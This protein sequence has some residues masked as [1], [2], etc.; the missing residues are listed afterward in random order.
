M[1]S[2][3]FYLSDRKYTNTPNIALRQLIQDTECEPLGAH[4]VSSN[5]CE[6]V[7]IPWFAP[8]V[9]SDQCEPF[10]PS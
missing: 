6:P 1:A 8:S 3:S 5:E 10:D 4:G 2:E 7:L 9:R